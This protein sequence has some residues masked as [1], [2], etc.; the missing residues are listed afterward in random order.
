[1][2]QRFGPAIQVFNFC[3]KM[4]CYDECRVSKNDEVI[5][6]SCDAQI[7][8]DSIKDI[9]AVDPE[10]EAGTDETILTVPFMRFVPAQFGC[11]TDT[12]VT[13]EGSHPFSCFS[14]PLAT[15]AE[16]K[17][18]AGAVLKIG[19]H[20][21][22]VLDMQI[23]GHYWNPFEPGSEATADE[24]TKT[25]CRANLVKQRIIDAAQD[26][27]LAMQADASFE[28]NGQFPTFDWICGKSAPKTGTEA[29][30]TALLGATGIC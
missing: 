18:I 24:K 22:K 16:I 26:E 13:D 21:T 7:A 3:Q 29:K 12:C 20:E 19:M 9:L 25:E 27:Y 6:T 4:K 23:T 30:T 11:A 15:Q 1:M 28:D 8:L 10:E 14:D 17:K 5:L 2:E